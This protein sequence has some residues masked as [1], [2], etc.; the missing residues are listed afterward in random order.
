MR[1]LETLYQDRQLA[2]EDRDGEVDEAS[3]LAVAKETS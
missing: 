2:D 1:I 3:N